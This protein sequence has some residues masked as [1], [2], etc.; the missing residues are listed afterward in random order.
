MQLDRR[1]TSKTPLLVL[2]L[3]LG[4]VGCGG[5][6]GSKSA[7]ELA[8]I[9]MQLG[10]RY[11]NLNKLDSAKENLLQ[12]LQEDGGNHQTFNALGVLYERLNQPDSAGKYYE[13]ALSLVSDDLSVLNNYG[14]FLCEHNEKAKGI[15]YLEQAVASPLNDRPWLAL[16]NAGL[17]LLGL[18]DLIKAEAYFREAL[19]Q[20]AD[21]EPALQAMQNL[22]Y[23]K[24]DFWAAKGY[25]QRYL[26]LANHTAETLWVAWQ[27]ERALGNANSAGEYKRLLLEQFPLSE[28]AKK[29]N[30]AP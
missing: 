9:H 28:H 25:L 13:K 17:C 1:L 8:D 15:K 11:M 30:A 19:Q 26:A 7:A 27:V 14:R 2:S 5:L 10:V 21:Y 20:S 12:A 6:G 22:S 4:L 3:C 18:G 24:G 29:I 23:Q 16:T